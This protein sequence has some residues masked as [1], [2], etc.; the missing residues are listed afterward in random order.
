MNIQF[1]MPKTSNKFVGLLN[2][3]RGRIRVAGLDIA[4]L[5]AEAVVH[6]GVGRSR[7]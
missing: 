7:P 4:G 6:H 2:G 5:S 3:V 1:L